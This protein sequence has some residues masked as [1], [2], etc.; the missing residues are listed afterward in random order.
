MPPAILFSSF[1][2]NSTKF[3][4]GGP[5]FSFFCVGKFVCLVFCQLRE[6]FP[7]TCGFPMQ[8]YNSHPNVRQPIASLHCQRQPGHLISTSGYGFDG[9][10]SYDAL[11]LPGLSLQQQ[12][13]TSIPAADSSRAFTFVFSSDEQEC[14]LGSEE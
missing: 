6:M 2:I 7:S 9:Q 14:I 5:I 13:M 10:R 8:F 11:Y 4:P 1:I 3:S 12:P